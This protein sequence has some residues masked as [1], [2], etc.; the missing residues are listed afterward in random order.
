VRATSGTRIVAMAENDEPAPTAD[1]PKLKK[2]DFEREL[3]RL[4]HELV[5]LQEYIKAKGLKVV[6]IFE[7]R[8][9]AGKGGV[10]KRIT[11]N[12][13]P[14]AWRIAAL[15]A[16]TER[17]RSQWYFQRYVAH[18]PAAGEV[19]LFDR[20]WYNRA[21]VERVMGFCTEEEYQEFMRSC[22]EF[23]RMLVRSGIIL[24][25]YWFSVSDEEQEKR[26]QA[27]ID[28]PTRRWKLSPMDLAARE[29]WVDYSRAK[30][31]MFAHTD[32]KQAPWWVV[33]ADDK[34]RARLNC[35]THLL[36]MIPYEDVIPPPLELPPRQSDEGYVRPPITDQ[37]FVPE[38]F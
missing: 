7:G 19:V 38:V 26:F 31:V 27:R 16:P 34:R 22:P 4:Q 36:S 15:A 5:V 18:L 37:T 32:I 35:I 14:R 29:R 17:E 10:I 9:A 6:V 28:D 23:E 33:D 21:G 11:E 2:K 8:D 12:V 25:K 13:S 20:S 1:K 30:D 3:D 24:I